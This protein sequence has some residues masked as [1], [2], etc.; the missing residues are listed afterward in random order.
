MRRA[1]A[2]ASGA[3]VRH[4]A[5]VVFRMRRVTVC[6]LALLVTALAP[7][8]AHAYPSQVADCNGPAGDP[9]PGS[10]AYQQRDRQNMLCATERLEDEHANPAFGHAFGTETPGKYAGQNAA[11]ATDPAHPHLTLGQ[12]VPGGSTTDPFRTLN[13][14]TAAKRGRADA[15]SFTASNGA[16]LNGF[17]FR[18][19]ASVKGPYP[20]VVITTGSI[21]GYQEMY[22]WAAEGLAEAGYEVLTYDVQGQ[23][24]SDTFPAME[25]CTSPDNCSGVPFQQSYNFFQGTI[26]A[27]NYFTSSANPGRADLDA[28]RIGI[29]GHSLGASAVST[30]GQC[31]PGVK[32]IV[33]WDNLAPAGDKCRANGETNY[34]AGTPAAPT[35]EVP[36][37]GMNAEYFFNPTPTDTP[38]APDAKWD[39]FKA[40]R[41]AGTDTM[42]IGL[43]SSTHLEWTYVPYILPASRLGE[44]VAMYYTLAWFDRY[45]R[46]DDSALG[47]LTATTFDDSADRSSIG[48]GTF[49][50]DA[51]AADPANPEAGN[52]P[53]LIKGLKVADRLS[54]YYA[55]AYDITGAHGN[56]HVSCTDMR[57]GCSAT[58]TR[59]RARARRR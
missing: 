48:A 29:A 21:Q 6:L 40:L 5:R 56:K 51:A 33:A 50:P 28:K 41:A 17:V 34:P 11:M 38:P 31:Y 58:T 16:K 3:Q 1:F 57:K 15:I 26:D 7:A 14:W 32:A 49:S 54:F 25:N 42:Q 39:G 35:N 27:L 8:A 10:D 19:P 52:V 45:V 4:A 47:R 12:L 37:L 55:S 59:T 18:P 36:A 53:N 20:G 2:H 22:F 30:V 13:R 43:R 23:G 9:A 46:G 24:N 44:R